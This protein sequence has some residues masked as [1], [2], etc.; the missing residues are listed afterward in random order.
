MSDAKEPPGSAS[1]EHREARAAPGSASTQGGQT[2]AHSAPAPAN[3]TQPPSNGASANGS[4]SSDTGELA[5]LVDAAVPA[6]DL[7]QLTFDAERLIAADPSRDLDERLEAYENIIDSEIG[8]T[9]QVR[10]R[11]LER[12]V[13]KRQLYLKFEG[14]NTTGTQKDRIA[15]AQAMDAL[16]QGYDSITTATCGNYGVALA[17]A[18][19][20]ARLRCVIYMPETYKSPRVGEMESLGA[21]IVRVPGDY[22]HAVDVSGVAAT[23]T[24]IYDANPGGANT[25]LQLKAYGHIAYEIYDDLRDAPA[26]VAV[27]VS[28]GTTLA[29][30]YRGFLRLYRRGKTS[31]MPRFVAGS[32]Y[33]KNP[34]VQSFLKSAATC[35]DLAPEKIR[36]TETNE[37][38][39]N[40]HSTE[41]QEA[42][43]AVRATS[44]WAAYASDRSMRRTSR[45]LREKEGVTVLPAA[46][47]GLIALLEGKPDESITNDRFVAILTGR[48]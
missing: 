8:D 29:G 15:F 31:R 9:M 11:N 26:A 22:E 19:K 24:Q 6:A 21:R 40:R 17:L 25:N 4:T 38:L 44:G 43:A 36:E 13:G 30:I 3:G 16:R 34:I 33:R 46:T 23:E 7:A 37:P 45:L 1:T 28:N 47:A 35:E 48:R 42:L 41:G 27:P 2:G 20:C 39:I 5:I 14:G 12:E 18:A 32:S 10:A